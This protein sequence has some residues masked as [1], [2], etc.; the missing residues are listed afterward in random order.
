MYFWKAEELAL[1]LRERRVYSI[2]KVLSFMALVGQIVFKV[3]VL[4]WIPFLYR[5]LFAAYQ[6]ELARE[7]QQPTLQLHVYNDYNG[8]LTAILLP[9]FIVILLLFYFVYSG[10]NKSQFV[11]SVV[12]LNLPI[13]IRILAIT[14]A[15]FVSAVFIA[16]S[17]FTFKLMAL[18]QTPELSEGALKSAYQFIN[19]VNII[20]KLWSGLI[21]LKHAELIFERMN[22]WSWYFYCASQCFALVS[23]LWYIGS[24]RKCLA[25]VYS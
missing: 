17:Y 15:I 5:T 23:T 8:L 20:G 22:M 18:T 16:G 7:I 6:H 9:S 11:E 12:S 1:Q 4:T 13:S 10:R 14:T 24:L 2:D 19:K 3:T 25:K 21:A